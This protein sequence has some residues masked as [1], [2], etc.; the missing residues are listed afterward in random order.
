[1]SM[2][3]DK[4]KGEWPMSEQ[5]GEFIRAPGKDWG[6]LARFLRKSAPL[7]PNRDTAR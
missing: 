2:G 4:R 6:M 5:S 1:M 3:E 7:P